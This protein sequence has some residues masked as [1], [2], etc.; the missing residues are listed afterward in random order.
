MVG[1]KSVRIVAMLSL[2]SL[3]TIIDSDSNKEWLISFDDCYREG[4][5]QQIVL[6]ISFFFPCFILSISAV[7]RTYLYNYTMTPHVKY[8]SICVQREITLNS[9]KEISAPQIIQGR[10]FTTRDITSFTYQVMCWRE[11]TISRLFFFFLSFLI[12]FSLSFPLISLPCFWF[13]DFFSP[14]LRGGETPKYIPLDQGVQK[15]QN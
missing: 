3:S 4:N 2:W 9:G 13:F 14:P 6:L 12:I 5:S 7:V 11:F 1:K 15:M 8:V 10:E